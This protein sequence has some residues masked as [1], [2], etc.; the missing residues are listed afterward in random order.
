MIAKTNVHSDGCGA[1]DLNKNI[2][3]YP[4]NQ[5]LAGVF[6]S[7]QD[8]GISPG[9]TFYGYSVVGN[10]VTVSINQFS[11]FPKSTGSTPGGWDMTAGGHR[12]LQPRC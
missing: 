1:K 2:L 5:K 3:S 8:L 11:T 10:D 6:V 7:Y 4:S 9:Q 12:C